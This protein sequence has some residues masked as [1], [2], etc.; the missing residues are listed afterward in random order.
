MWGELLR[1][2]G[3]LLFTFSWLDQVHNWLGKDAI[4]WLR[5]GVFLLTMTVVSISL[6]A[7]GM[8]L[9]RKRPE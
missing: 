9:E 7:A 8:A 6:V 1:E 3:L 5:G 4:S 2:G